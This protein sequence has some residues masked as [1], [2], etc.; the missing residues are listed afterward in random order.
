MRYFLQ[1]RDGMALEL[2]A[3]HGMALAIAFPHDVEIDRENNMV[4]IN[5]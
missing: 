5:E 4:W 2:C 3:K 1:T